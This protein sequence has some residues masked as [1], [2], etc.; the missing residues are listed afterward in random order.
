MAFKLPSLKFR[1]PNILGKMKSPKPA[2]VKPAIKSNY[3]SKFVDNGMINTTGTTR[4]YAN[5]GDYRKP[6]Q[7]ANKRTFGQ[8]ID[9]KRRFGSMSNMPR[10]NESF[11]KYI[12]RVK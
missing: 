1:K 7:P 11:G 10:T 3:G 12:N 5:K 4:G 2:M 6:L 9:K 8:M